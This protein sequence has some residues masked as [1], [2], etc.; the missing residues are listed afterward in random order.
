VND[1]FLIFRGIKQLAMCS[2]I[3]HA[4]P[5]LVPLENTSIS[6][7]RVNMPNGR[8]FDALVLEH[9]T[10]LGRLDFVFTVRQL[11]SYLNTIEQALSETVL[12]MEQ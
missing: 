4:Q 9:Q 3:E 11:R 2:P 12:D 1:A 10:Q 8:Q 5:L 7:Q 6:E